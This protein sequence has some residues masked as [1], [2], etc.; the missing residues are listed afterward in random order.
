M[1]KRNALTKMARILFKAASDERDRFSRRYPSRRKHLS[2]LSVAR[3]W[4]QSISSF[5]QFYRPKS[6]SMRLKIAVAWCHAFTPLPL[7]VLL[8]QVPPA[9]RIWA[10]VDANENKLAADF[11]LKRLFWILSWH[12][13]M[14]TGDWCH[15]RCK[16]S[17]PTA[18]VVMDNHTYFK[19][20]INARG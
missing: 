11:L 15:R 20:T 1:L 5:Y 4:R 9:A 8:P 17:S 12:Y 10:A 6:A 14:K 2:S 13:R 3:R 7:I 18:N 16:F 19:A